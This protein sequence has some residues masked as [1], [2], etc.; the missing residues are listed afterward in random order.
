MP[1]VYRWKRSCSWPFHRWDPPFRRFGRP[2]SS[3]IT[4]KKPPTLRFRSAGASGRWRRGW[5]EWP[6]RHDGKRRSEKACGCEN[7]ACA[8]FTTVLPPGGD[9]ITH[10]VPFIRSSVC[11]TEYYVIL[12]RTQSRTWGGSKGPC[13]LHTRWKFTVKSYLQATKFFFDTAAGTSGY[14][15]TSCGIS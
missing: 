7:L 15:C 4:R 8:R 1:S 6:S 2:E 12:P 3:G 5:H 11:S 13:T 9:R 10:L 14:G